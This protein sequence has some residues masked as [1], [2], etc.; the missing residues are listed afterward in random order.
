VSNNSSASQPPL[1]SER[2]FGLLF[3][4]IGLGLAV[5]GHFKDWPTGVSTGLA[6]AGGVFLLL[7]WLAPSVLSPLNKAWFALGLLLGKIVSPLVLG[8]MFYLLVTPFA[9][10][11]RMMGRDELRLKKRQVASYWIDRP[12]GAPA[13]ESF[14]NQF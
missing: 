2:K 10:V 6:V 13:S 12:V 9:L 14:K 3:A 1:P 4:A 8:L 5:W 11:G 7:A